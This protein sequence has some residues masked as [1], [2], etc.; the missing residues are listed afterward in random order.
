MA[1]AVSTAWLR[2]WGNRLGTSDSRLLSR[3]LMASLGMGDAA[4]HSA[5]LTTLDDNNMRRMSFKRGMPRARCPLAVVHMDL[6]KV[7][8][9]SLPKNVDGHVIGFQYALVCVDDYSGFVKCYFAKRKTDVPKLIQLFL[10]DMGISTLFGAHMVLH[11]GFARFHTDGGKEFNSEEV[12]AILRQYGIVANITSAPDTPSSNG[13]AERMIQTLCKDARF[14]LALSG[15]SVKYWHYAFLD[16]ANARNL[17]AS[18]KLVDRDGNVAWVSPHHLF[19]GEK[20]DLSHV[21]M[22]GAPCRFLPVSILEKQRQGKLGKRAVRGRVLVYG[23]FGIQVE[24]TVRRLLGY[25]VLLDDGRIKY[26]RNVQI[27]ERTLLEGGDSLECELDSPMEPL[28]EVDIEHIGEYE[29][30]ADAD[31][32]VDEPGQPEEEELDTTHDPLR[33]DRASR[34]KTGRREGDEVAVQ[35][36]HVSGGSVFSTSGIPI[37]VAHVAAVTVATMDGVPIDIPQNTAEARKSPQAEIW[38]AAEQTHYDMWRELGVLKEEEVPEGQKVIPSRN[39]YEVKTAE[40]GE[41]VRTKSR[42][43]LQGFRQRPGEDFEQ[44]FAPTIRGEQVRFMLAVATK[45]LGT[46]TDFIVNGGGIG[47]AMLDHLTLDHVVSVGDV[48]DAYLRSLLPDAEQVLFALPPGY[49]PS[50]RARLG[51]KVVGRALK[52]IP[53][54]KQAGRVWYRRLREDLMGLGFVPCEAAPCIYIL[55][56]ET[57][58]L[59]IGHFVD[60]LLFLNL[61][62]DTHAFAGIK[63]ALLGKYEVRYSDKLRKFLGAQFEEKEDGLYLHLEQYITDM[64]EKFLDPS[65]KPAETPEVESR[66]D[67]DTALLLRS[68]IKR[69]Q[70]V[71]GALMYTM[72]TCRP[73]IAHAVNMLARRMTTPRV[74]DLDSARRVLRYLKGTRRHG[75]LFR[76]KEDGR[77]PGLVAYADSDWAADT[78]QR[79]STTGFVVLYNGVAISWHSGLQS[80]VALSTCE[81]E[82]IALSEC[83]RELIYLRQLG[84]FL[85]DPTV[86]AATDIHEDNQGTIDL[87]NN[88]VHHKR[89]KHIDTKY[90]YIRLQQ[91]NGQV[92]VVKIGTKLNIADIFTKATDRTTFLRHQATLMYWTPSSKD[93][94]ARE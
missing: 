56:V 4:L 75:L 63:Q 33:R 13:I 19:F 58:I 76:F 41:V 64:L 36:A 79:R 60:D 71:T 40:N 81:A 31:E 93:Y 68:D 52:A 65:A 55:E 45:H 35:V 3:T 12:S 57:G 59:V 83:C 90:H 62:K 66:S 70:E 23:G 7:D 46:V 37:D 67:G 84:R 73:D 92:N 8:K 22:F 80:I 74:C 72:T 24:N 21:V 94:K 53:G 29:L 69:Y 6:V 26:S 32:S 54:M 51:Y 2:T 43:V 61:S 34:S 91:A 30:A 87:V 82:Y 85:R 48:K 86:D 14:R 17:L 16:A 5:E 28:A 38:K 44:T 49:R 39:V 15:L 10:D 11:K 88:P 77:F 89:S 9:L 78:E 47:E 18:R 1:S 27:D 50:I 20:P 42:T 25:V